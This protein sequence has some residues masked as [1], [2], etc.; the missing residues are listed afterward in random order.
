METLMPLPTMPPGPEID[1][2]EGA[3]PKE[4]VKALSAA[5]VAEFQ[6]LVDRCEPIDSLIAR[7]LAHRRADGV[8]VVA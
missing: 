1:M 8:V 6:K 4:L 3:D 7:G 2:A 5:S